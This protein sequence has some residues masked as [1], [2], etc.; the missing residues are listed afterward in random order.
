MVCRLPSDITIRGRRTYALP[1]Q[2]LLVLVLVMKAA[3][4][5]LVFWWTR[6]QIGECRSLSRRQSSTSFV[7]GTSGLSGPCEAE[8]IE[9]K[10][11]M[12]A[13]G[14]LRVRWG[15]VIFQRSR[16][17]MA[18]RTCRERGGVRMKGIVFNLLEEVVTRQYGENT[19]DDLLDATGL[20]GAYTSLGS[21][22][23]SDLMTLVEA[24]AGKLGVASEDVVRWFGTA[25]LPLLAERYPQF[26]ESHR[27]SRSFLLTLNDV[28]H[29]EVRKLYPGAEV[30]EF[31]FDTP[32]D[33]VLR[34]GYR[35]H[36][37]LC[38]FGEGLIQG[39][40]THFGEQVRVEQPECM[41]RGDPRCLMV[42]S[43]HQPSQEMA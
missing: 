24:A 1:N 25:A 19:W 8:I 36:R 32:S 43:F 14:C 13:D 39:A 21:Y 15:P 9:G 35:S 2:I 17:R 27:S 4:N 12:K 30:P 33:E 20:E 26:F 6:R 16:V 7:R 23:D 41:N 5:S 42:C 31:E 11:N 34:I 18:I 3:F 29:P 40:A 28:I 38:A 22:P 37:R 10:S